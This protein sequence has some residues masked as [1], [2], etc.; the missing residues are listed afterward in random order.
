[1]IEEIDVTDEVLFSVV[2]EGWLEKTFV[3][4]VCGKES[5]Y[6]P[7]LYNQETRMFFNCPHCG[8]KL[9]FRTSGDR[10]N[11]VIQIIED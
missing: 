1:M 9:Y 3:Q 11:Q 2:N 7:D 6:F 10:R 4:C 8:A 5:R